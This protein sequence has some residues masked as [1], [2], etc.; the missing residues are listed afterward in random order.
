VITASINITGRRNNS[1]LIENDSSCSKQLTFYT[2]Q[3]EN[4]PYQT[5]RIIVEVPATAHHA[6]N[7]PISSPYRNN[8]KKVPDP[9]ER[10]SF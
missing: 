2:K 3:V 4:I 7:S 8:P 1:L 6:F 9:A 10:L 5:S